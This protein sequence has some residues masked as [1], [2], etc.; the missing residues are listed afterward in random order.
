[1]HFGETQR[2]LFVVFCSSLFFSISDGFA[3]AILETVIAGSSRFSPSS[4]C[5]ESSFSSRLSSFFSPWP[6]GESSSRSSSYF[7]PWSRGESSSRLSPPPP[8]NRG[9]PFYLPSF[10]CGQM[11]SFFSIFF[12]VAFFSAWTFELKASLS[13]V[14]FANS[15]FIYNGGSFWL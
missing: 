15:L 9:G 3:Y 7:S 5:G 4:R 8:L 12:A 14:F 6:R 11:S 10:G 2:N 13:M 1:M